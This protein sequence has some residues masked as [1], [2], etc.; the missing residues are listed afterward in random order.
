MEHFEQDIKGIEE[1]RIRFYTACLETFSQLDYN[2]PYLEQ[3]KQDIERLKN[4]SC[5]K[6]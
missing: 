1:N 4:K 2:D 5:Q 6:D 3:I